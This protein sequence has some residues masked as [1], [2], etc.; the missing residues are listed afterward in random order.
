M[1]TYTLA[2]IINLLRDNR[3]ISCGCGS[4]LEND[5][6]SYNLVYRNVGFIIVYIWLF[7]YGKGLLL[8]KSILEISVY[9]LVTICIILLFSIL[10]E[11]YQSKKQLAKILKHF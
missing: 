4:I 6:L 1:F 5:V 3:H 2:I 10:K 7:M 11:Y 9:F 8:E